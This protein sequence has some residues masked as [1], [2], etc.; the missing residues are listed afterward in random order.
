M[1]KKESTFTNMFLTLLIIT[2]FS[3][4][5][6]SGVYTLTKEPIAEV[7]RMKQQK[8][9]EQVMPPFESYITREV[10]PASGEDSIVLFTGTAGKDTIGIAVNTYSYNGY[11][12]I[13][14]LMVG[15]IP[16]GT[17]HNIVVL[18]Q[19]ETPGL[20]TKMTTD[21][22]DQFIGKNLK[23]FNCTVK[24]DGG[25]VDAITA[26][27]VSSRAFCDA[28]NRAYQTYQSTNTPQNQ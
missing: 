20:G 23:D 13:I 15:F 4:L 6:A 12:G 14:K 17:I 11:G 5:A 27:T 25:Q 26:A 2:V 18:E 28:V 8:A 19:K 3:S 21:W 10:M 24:K 1:A 7:A 22:K 16:D 9:I